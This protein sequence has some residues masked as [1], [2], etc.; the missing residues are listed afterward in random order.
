MNPSPYPAP[1]T[2][3]HGRAL[4]AK[5]LLIVGAVVTGMSL[6]AEALSFAFPP[7]TEDQELGDNPGSAIVALRAATCDNQPIDVHVIATTSPNNPQ[8]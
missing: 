4:T 2:S 8:G 6:L 5:I 1:F 3:A 7:L